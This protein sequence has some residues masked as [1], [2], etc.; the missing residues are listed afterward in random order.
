MCGV[1]PPLNIALRGGVGSVSLS[2]FIGVACVRGNT[3]VELQLT[4]F[5]PPSFTCFPLSKYKD[6]I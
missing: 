6:V 2:S 5:S 4:F 1:T 3:M